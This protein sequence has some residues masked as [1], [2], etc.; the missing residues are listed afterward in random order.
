MHVVPRG[1]GWAAI[2]SNAERASALFAT[3]AD[4]I[5]RATELAKKTEAE[6]VIHRQNGSIQ[7]CNSFGNDPCPPRDKVH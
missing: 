1:E 4:A 7:N 5:A 2:R 3:K 6:L